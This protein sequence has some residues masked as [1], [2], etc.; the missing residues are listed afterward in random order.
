MSKSHHPEILIGEA[1][2]AS[3]TGLA[4]EADARLPGVAESL[5]VELDR[6][7]VVADK[8][9]PPNVVRMGSSVVF[10]SD[11]GQQR[12]VILTYPA[13]A[14][15]A[16]DR[17]SVMTPIGAALIGLAQGQSIGWVARDGRKHELTV[18]RVEQETDGDHDDP[19]PMAA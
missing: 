6:A 15:I 1:E 14:D 12:R 7:K 16:A 4:V 11:D 19:G 18:L 13:R 3:L 8:E 17:I 5:L 2:H 9:V 10:R